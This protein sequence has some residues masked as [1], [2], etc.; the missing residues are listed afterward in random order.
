MARLVAAAVL[1]EL[2]AV[3]LQVPA[4][5]MAAG[6]VVMERAVLEVVA[7]QSVL[8]GRVIYVN[9]LQLVYLGL[10]NFFRRKHELI[11]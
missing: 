10:T 1:A 6:Q 5:F 2:L 9:S 11:Y 7:A 8:S 4:V 3:H